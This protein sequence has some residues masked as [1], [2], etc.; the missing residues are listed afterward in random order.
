MAITGFAA[1]VAFATYYYL[2][3]QPPHLVSYASRDVPMKEIERIA[4]E[5]CQNLP[6]WADP[7]AVCQWVGY[8]VDSLI[9]KLFFASLFGLGGFGVA[10][11]LVRLSESRI[12]ELEQD[13]DDIVTGKKIPRY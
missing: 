8:E 4:E 7:P 12:R 6:V 9:E 11:T 10:H 13:I 2:E 3:A 1:V 5:E